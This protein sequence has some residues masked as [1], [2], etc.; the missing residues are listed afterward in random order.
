MTFVF[1]QPAGPSTP[2]RHAVRDAYRTDEGAAIEAL[3]E[4]ADLQD[5][6]RRR[7][8]RIARDIVAHVR[9]KR[10]EAGGIDAFMHEYDLSSQEGVALMCLAEALLRVPDAET[11]DRLIRDK[12]AEA[13]WKQH[14]GDSESLFVNASTWGLMLTGRVVRLD[15]DMAGTATGVLG[16]LVNRVGEPIIREAMVHAMRI[17]GRQFVMG[18]TI[19][20]A[21]ERTRGEEKLGYRHSYDMLGEA[22]RT[23][24]DADRYMAAYEDAIDRLGAATSDGEL[25]ARPSISVKLSAL[26]P[27]YEIA[28]TDRVTGE[29][30]PRLV[31]LAARARDRGIALTVDAEEADRLDPS[32]D[33]FAAASGSAELKGWDGLG[34]AVQA[35]QKR[36]VHVIAWLDDLA[37]QT[38]RRIPVRLVKGAYWDTEVKL[39]Q[40]QG[41]E[42]YPV[43]TRKASTDVSYIAC[44]RVMLSNS[45]S[46]YPQ[47]ATHNAQTLASVMVLAG[48]GRN[49]FE[50]QR[51]HGMG[52]ALYQ[53]LV[54]ESGRGISCR[55]YAPVGSHEDLL[56][57][58]VRRLLENGA[59]TSFV[60]RIVD[61]AMPIEGLI[62]DPVKTVWAAIPRAHP[63]IVLP[64][65]LFGADR[66][67]ARGFDL[68]DEDALVALA[69]KMKNA[70]AQPWRSAP[71]VAGKAVPGTVR[72]IR[73]PA[74]T[75]DVVGEVVEADAETVERALAIAAAAAPGWSKTPVDERAACL[76]RTADLL[77]ANIARAMA[78]AT[79]EA[80]KTLADGIAEVREAVDFFRYYAQRARSDFGDPVVLPGPT[81][82]VNQ[83]SLHGRGV[84]ACISPWNFPLAIFC[85]QITAALAAGNTVISK[86]AEQT[87]LMAAFAV[88]LM[89][90]AGVPGDV[91]QLLPGDGAIVGARLVSD[92]R[93]SGV[94]FTGSTETARLIN[95]ALAE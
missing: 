21:L 26:H 71:L 58:L 17:V 74:D 12:I 36:A 8:E 47:F 48:E 37:R 80:G 61:D 76:E 19:D 33:V 28:Q 55:I 29:L 7:V 43:F 94:A 89:H 67:N 11:A 23:M 46:F 15:P 44:A 88:G 22:A 50:F 57:Y 41:L 10:R 93:V 90:E 85:G 32:L 27:R 38:R 87:P 78:I 68:S 2:L 70:A 69:D 45:R 79:R 59:N 14:V 3:L 42:G 56:A 63:S 81:G 1:R 95:R 73:N 34:L 9:A 30:V 39:A 18:R 51:L 84:F 91:L 4:I 49:D 77:E 72:Q 25:F 24:A 60:N 35:Y 13:D 31:A 16:R 20:E 92:P 82:E 52:Q 64:R 75:R 40:E 86:P 62:E 6:E 54:E 66:A 83:I 53:R 65:D 5:V